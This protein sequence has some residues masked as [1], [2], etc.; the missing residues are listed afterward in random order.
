MFLLSCPDYL[1][2][3]PACQQAAEVAWWLLDS[4]GGLSQR[5][6]SPSL[7]LLRAAQAYAQGYSRGAVDKM[8]NKT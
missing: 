6:A 1:R 4:R 3:S 2:I 5:Y 7:L 8:K